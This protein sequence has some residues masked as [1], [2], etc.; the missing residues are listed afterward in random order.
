MCEKGQIESLQLAET[1]HFYWQ[2]TDVDE[3]L[4]P[5]QQFSSCAKCVDL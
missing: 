5:C 4:R 2:H 1:G 3:S